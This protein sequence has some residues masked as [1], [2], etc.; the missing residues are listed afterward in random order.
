MTTTIPHDSPDAPV[1]PM[2]FS[3]AK[4]DEQPARAQSAD[5]APSVDFRP[6]AGPPRR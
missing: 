2:V 3:H 5:Q 6:P 4:D 1:P